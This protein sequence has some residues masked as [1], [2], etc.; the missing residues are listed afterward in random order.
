MNGENNPNFDMPSLLRLKDLDIRRLASNKPALTA[1]EYFYTLS[2]FV[3]LIPIVNSDLSDILE[4]NY[5]ENSFKSLRELI[6]LFEGIGC[7]KFISDFNNIINAGKTNSDKVAISSIKHIM[8]E[9]SSL[10]AQIIDAAKKC[11]NN[12]IKDVVKASDQNSAGQ[13]Q[14]NA[15]RTLKD[16]INTLDHEEVTRKLKILVIDDSLVILERV[17]SILK[18]EYK[19]YGMAN[20]ELVSDFLKQITPELFLLDY[21]MPGL[22][23]F[24]LIPIIRKFPEHKTTPIIILTSMGTPEHVSA[25]FSLGACDFIV[26]PFQENNMREKIA[27][28]I[29]RKKAF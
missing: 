19:V 25:A 27:K 9:F 12:D 1:K 29:V 4:H 3:N 10:C 16:V 7:H 13:S 17:S 14:M 22:S 18:N 8:G 28:H 15:A 5:S 24:D 11:R 2:K 26:K 6:V 21:K 20:P 23:G